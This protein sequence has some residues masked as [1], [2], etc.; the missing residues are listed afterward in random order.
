[1]KWNEMK[2]ECQLDS[3]CINVFTSLIVKT[4][5]GVLLIFIKNITSSSSSSSS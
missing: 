4:I 2:W 3:L 5:M 1:M